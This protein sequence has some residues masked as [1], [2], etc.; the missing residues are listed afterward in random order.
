MQTIADWATQ[1]DY[2]RLGIEEYKLVVVVVVILFHC[3]SPLS[4][5]RSILLRL[6]LAESSSLLI[7]RV[8]WIGSATAARWT[9]NTPQTQHTS[10]T[11]G[12]NLH[13]TNTQ[14]LMTNCAHL[15]LHLQLCQCVCWPKNMRPHHRRSESKSESQ[16]RRMI[17]RETSS[18][19][20]DKHAHTHTQTNIK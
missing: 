19:L 5:S 13:L 14:L 7:L 8:S 17:V 18:I 20:I 10:A 15:H 12:S 4:L 6:Q 16:S 11:I 3:F 1:T 9:Q 2:K